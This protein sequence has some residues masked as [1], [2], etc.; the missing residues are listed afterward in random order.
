M[1]R[2]DG[3][4]ADELGVGRPD[5]SRSSVLVAEVTDALQRERRRLEA[6]AN[7]QTIEAV[8]REIARDLAAEAGRRLREAVL[9]R[10]DEAQDVGPT[11]V[12]D[13]QRF[14]LTFRI[15]HICLFLSTLTLIGTGLPLRYAETSWAHTFFAWIGGVPAGALVHRV[16]AAVLIAVG[17]F[18]IGY[19]TLMPEGRREFRTLLPTLKDVGDLLRNLAYFVGLRRSRPRFDRYS[20]VEK[21]DYWAVYWG[22]VIMIGS[23]L[24][25]WLPQIV[26]RYLPKYALDI[27]QVVHS[28]EALLAATAIIIWHFYNVHFNSES[29]PMDWVWLNGRISKERMRTH[30]PLEYERCFGSAKESTTREDLAR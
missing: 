15:Q 30:H 2:K 8:E 27:A 13:Y 19:I 10:T 16:A 25:L 20:Y 6:Q 28:D 9:R 4:D 12:G 7:S 29:F 22:M 5:P 21:F 11:E 26:M 3:Q 14:G 18:H 23:G 1:D 24:L 17:A